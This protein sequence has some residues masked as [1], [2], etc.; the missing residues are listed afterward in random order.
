MK[1]KTKL[2]AER[3]NLRPI[4]PSDLGSIHALHALPETDQ[5]NTLGIPNNIEETKMIIS[6]W[7][8]D[9]EK[10]EPT[11]FTFTIET[12]ANSIFVGLIVLKLGN[13]K[14]RTAEV[15]YKLHPDYWGKGYG[16][17]SLRTLI[18]FGFD[19]LHLHRIEAGC[20]VEN[21][22]SIKVLEKAGMRREGRKRKVLPLKTGWSDNFEYAI[23]ET[24]EILVKSY[25]L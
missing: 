20:A 8:S 10:A 21:I 24:D 25:E 9:N 15:W 18:R 2:S 22:A 3:L 12:K 16:T 7:I 13:R 23:L 4:Q 14:Y 19:Q 6:P 11:N 1:P 5:Y 17:E